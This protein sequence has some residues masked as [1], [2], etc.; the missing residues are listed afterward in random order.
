MSLKVIGL[1]LGR[2]GTFSLKAALE[3]LGFGPCHHMERV[4]RD[5]SVQVPLWNEVLD[6]NGGFESVYK[7]MNSAVD[8]P[9][10]AF[11][12]ELYAAYPN[13]KFIL[14]HRSKE[15]WA[16]SFGSTIYKLL[17]GR[18]QAPP[19]VRDWLNMVVRVLDKTGFSMDLDF[20]GLA[21]KFEAHNE[22]VQN[23]IPK[24]QLL[25]YQVK[26]GWQPLC[27]FLEV[28]VPETEFPRTNNREEFW[29]LVN[30]TM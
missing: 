28:D 22:A 11:H 12:E 21:A 25:V 9:T 5:M 20:D 24:E 18:D 17:G 6:K 27:E 15:S 23:L 10:A 26:E 30:S 13:A 7:G 19:P 14:T 16:E 29:E 3:E 8:W 1:G 2:T 4:A